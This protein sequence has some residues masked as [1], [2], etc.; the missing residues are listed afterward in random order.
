MNLCL[1][2]TVAVDV[3][4]LTDAAQIGLYRMSD[5]TVE[6]IS[7][8]ALGSA[9]E[10]NRFTSDKSEDYAVAQDA[11]GYLILKEAGPAHTHKLCNDAA[12][13]DHSNVTF[14][15]WTDATK[16]PTSGSY[17]LEVDVELSTVLTLSDNL[18]LCLN[19]HSITQKGNA[20]VFY[21]SVG[22]TLTITLSIVES[23]Q[24]ARNGQIN[25]SS[26]IKILNFCYC[27]FCIVLR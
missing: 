2:T 3:S 7:T 15:P 11:E 19:G 12:C 24:Q 25:I 1:R 26:Q 10:L 5:R 4:G 8:K 18:T 6:R 20:R 14:Q 21:V 16:L 13:A 23:S 27:K 9:N 22:K 17:F